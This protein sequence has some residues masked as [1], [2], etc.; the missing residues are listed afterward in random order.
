MKSITESVKK[1]FSKKPSAKSKA[2]EPE[3]SE[4][5]PEKLRQVTQILANRTLTRKRDEP[6]QMAE[7]EA[8]TRLSLVNRGIS[9]LIK[10]EPGLSKHIESEKKRQIQIKY[11]QKYGYQIP[12]TFNGLTWNPEGTRIAF[13]SGNSIFIID[14][15]D[16][17]DGAPKEIRSVSLQYGEEIT[18][19]NWHPNG[20]SILTG[21]HA[22]GA[23]RYDVI[24]GHLMRT[25]PGKST[26]VALN[27]NGQYYASYGQYDYNNDI[28]IR[29]LDTGHIFRFLSGHSDTVKSVAWSPNSQYLATG[30]VDGTFRIWH[31]ATDEVKKK[32]V[33][34]VLTIAWSPDGRF[35]ATGSNDKMVRIWNANTG[36]MVS[37][38]ETGY[39]YGVIKVVWSP[40][41]KYLATA[42]KDDNQVKIWDATTIHKLSL[43][44]KK[45]L[46]TLT[47]DQ[48]VV[49]LAWSP[50]SHYLAIGTDS[51]D[52]IP[53]SQPRRRDQLASL[54]IWDALNKKNHGGK[55]RTTS[56]K[57]KAKTVTTKT[58]SKQN[59]K[60]I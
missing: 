49:Q 17:K 59:V 48:F 28:R 1:A 15:M 29:T 55:K 36:S 35:I 41:G 54:R 47:Q 60:F 25:Y 31:V 33:S 50:D 10:A 44:G 34:T 11:I 5:D 58:K 7:I 38:F 2:P 8:L 37:S 16:K 32:N 3:I 6:L 12:Y 9:K 45:P 26:K 40:D 13:G 51:Y 39:P 4:V 57:T 21:S 24:T 27:P 22:S 20:Q 30:S 52:Y 43:L 18:D 42:G 19:V 53:M 46:Y 14:P 23:N 56:T